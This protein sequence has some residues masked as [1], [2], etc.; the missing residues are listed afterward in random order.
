MGRLEENYSKMETTNIT[1]Q[2]NYNSLEENF[3]TLEEK[4]TSIQKSYS[5]LEENYSSLQQNFYKLE[6]N[7][8]ALQERISQLEKNETNLREEVNFLK[9]KELE[10]A[11]KVV[12]LNKHAQELKAFE[13]Q[14]IQNNQVVEEQLSSH[15]QIS[16]SLQSRIEKHEEE[17]IIL[18][19]NDEK[20]NDRITALEKN[21][22]EMEARLEGT[23][24]LNERLTELENS[25]IEIQL[26]LQNLESADVFL[27]EAHRM[28]MDKATTNELESKQMDINLA[29]IDNKVQANVQNIAMLK[30]NID[31]NTE[32][33]TKHNTV[34]NNH[35]EAINNN[36]E[37]ISK[38]NTVINTHTENINN[39]FATHSSITEQINLINTKSVDTWQ[40][41]D[42]IMSKHNETISS[43]NNLI[44]LD[45]QK[46]E[47]METELKEL[48]N[49]FSMFSPEI[50]KTADKLNDIDAHTSELEKKVDENALIGVRN[51]N[52]IKEIVSKISSQENRLETFDN[53]SESNKS[54]ITKINDH[55]ETINKTIQIFESRHSETIERIKEVTV[56]AGNID[57]NVKAQEQRM[58]QQKAND[59]NQFN[60]QLEQL[61]RQQE[62]SSNKM[63][64][65]D[66]DHHTLMEKLMG[67][68]R[69]LDTRLKHLD[70]IDSNMS[71]RFG[72]F[73]EESIHR[74]KSVED[75]N[76]YNREKL[77]L[78]EDAHQN[79]LQKAAY[80]ENLGDRVNQLDEMRQ[81][82][83]ARAKDEVDATVSQSNRLINTIQTDFEEKVKFM[84]NFVKDEQKAFINKSQEI[85]QEILTIKSATNAF[86]QKV[87]GFSKDHQMIINNI[88]E[89]VKQNE[90][91]IKH[92]DDTLDG[93][94]RTIQ[95]SE[96]KHV[97]TLSSFS[98]EL[99]KKIKEVDNS[100]TTKLSN[101][102]SINRD[103]F[104]KIENQ[105]QESTF[106]Q[107][108]KVQYVETLES[109]VNQMGEEQQ[110]LEK[111]T[112]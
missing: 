6:Q 79:Q 38:H 91:Q 20:L 55:M 43:I 24:K 39:I 12:S 4:N 1:L 65:I 112:R 11:K 59:F 97:D 60:N 41:I 42:N 103:N 102:E 109:K 98:N 54:R 47:D 74:I 63:S 107:A 40:S 106:I 96:G 32:N 37:N 72:I 31:T 110:K 104:E 23:H 108:E 14:Q 80:I 69:N 67:L 49:A 53:E 5:N 10:T 86:S 95:I 35:S 99:D 82:S 73:Q 22:T 28:L 8:L 18:N 44:G 26:K 52:N 62:G 9:A 13:E 17:T 75:E 56:L 34:I 78:L 61:K 51:T 83:E 21:E 50:S 3:T 89:R 19:K 16:K 100:F 36:T 101:Y 93:L 57:T 81:Q 27:Q 64:N 46:I 90:D 111:Q 30:L 84:E 33:I 70:D 58:E 48:G 92:I 94:H 66:A 105:V 85:N 68:E 25:E 29:R 71:S 45:K 77:I 15:T 87:E 88:E 2:N 7:N 76:K